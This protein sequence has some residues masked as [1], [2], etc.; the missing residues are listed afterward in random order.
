MIRM[1]LNSKEYEIMKVMWDSD[2]PMLVSEIVTKTKNVSD[3][4]VHKIINK[5]EQRG[6][7]EV[8]GRVRVVKSPGRLYA[9]TLSLTEYMA[10][11]TRE[12][13]RFNNRTLD[14]KE[15]L[16]YI[17]KKDKNKNIEYLKSVEEF[18]NEC[19]N[20]IKEKENE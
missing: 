8:V 12:V 3:G 18:L 10:T 5:L 6:F 7:I 15:L 20:V 4:S 17:I 13:Y 1:D 19:Q 9:P 14:L 16:T 11:L 2:R